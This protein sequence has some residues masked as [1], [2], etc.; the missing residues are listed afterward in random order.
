MKSFGE[1]CNFIGK[2][3]NELLTYTRK[4]LERLRKNLSIIYTGT[5]MTYN[6]KI[7]SRLYP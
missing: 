6:F 2:C 3:V 7:L 1:Y 4:E 5:V